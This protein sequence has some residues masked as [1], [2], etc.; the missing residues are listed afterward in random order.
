MMAA[1]PSSTSQT[2]DPFAPIRTARTDLVL[3]SQAAMVAT[4]ENDLE[5][6]ERELDAS[7]PPDLRDRL[8]DLFLL[9]LDQALA[10][11]TSLLW[12][13]RAMVLDDRITDHRTMVGSIGFHAPPHGDPP[14]AEVGYH[15]EPGY[16]RRGLAV[17]ALGAMLDWAAGQGI[18]QIR[19]SVSPVNDASLATIR[20]FGFRQVGVQMDEVDGEELIFEVDWPPAP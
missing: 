3:F 19:A 1:M 5:T 11:P 9:R 17:E 6:V 7:V 12:L 4:L 20:R 16:R 10:D 2:P 8:G 18:H 14:W 15:V 13:A